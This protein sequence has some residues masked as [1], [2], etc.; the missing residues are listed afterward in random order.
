MNQ[1]VI[2]D[3][4]IKDTLKLKPQLPKKFKLGIYFAGFHQRAYGEPSIR[5]TPVDKKD[6]ENLESEFLKTGRISEVVI[7]N[8]ATVSDHNIKSIRLAAAQH[9]LDAIMIITGAKEVKERAN[10]YAWTYLAILPIYFVNGLKSDA[11][12]ISRATMWDVR[13]QYLYLTAEAEDTVTKYH[14]LLGSQSAKEKA[15]EEAKKKSLVLL[16]NEIKKQFSIIK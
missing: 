11:L 8:Q 14:T 13:N 15:S 5:W 7:I 9:G 1:V 3:K 4:N 12:V 6:F 10:N 2:T 16:K